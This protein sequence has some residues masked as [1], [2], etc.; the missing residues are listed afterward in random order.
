MFRIKIIF[1][2]AGI[3]IGYMGYEEFAVSQKASSPAAEVELHALETS[4]E[5]SNNYIRIGEHWSIY[6]GSIYEYKVGKYETGDPDDNTSVTHTYYPIISN[7]HP[8][9]IK[10][11]ALFQKYGDAANI[12]DSVWPE[13]KQFT[14]LVKT[15]RFKTIGSIPDDWLESASLEGLVINRIENLDAEETDLLLQ[16]FPHINLNNVLIVEEARQPSS[17]GKSLGMMGGG[18]IL[19]LFGLFLLIPKKEKAVSPPD[20]PES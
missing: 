11:D 15:K 9:I 4:S 20:L 18:G 8:Y 7:A 12:P 5:L 14:V 19:S 10:T 3:F 13:F 16:S 1:I 6:P 2:V 17:K